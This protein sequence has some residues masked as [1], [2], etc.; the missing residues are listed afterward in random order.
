MR[1]VPVTDRLEVL[2]RGDL[3]QP[4]ALHDRSQ[5]LRVGR[6]AEDVRDDEGDAAGLD[7][8]DDVANLLLGRRD[9][10]LQ[11]DV[12]V[13]VG[14]GD[15]RV[16]VVTILSADEDAVDGEP[17]GDAVEEEFT[18]IGEAGVGREVMLV[19]DAVSHL[20]ARV[21]HGHQFGAIGM[22]ESPVRIARATG[23][24]THHGKT[25]TSHC[26]QPSADQAG[27]MQASSTDGRAGRHL[28]HHG[29]VS[30]PPPS[31]GGQV[32]VDDMRATRVKA[33]SI[34]IS[35]STYGLGF[36]ALAVTTGLSVAQTMALSILLFSGGSQF[37]FIGLI[38]AG[39]SGAAV[40][41]STLLGLRNGVYAIALRRLVPVTGL[42]RVLAAQLTIDESTAVA[43]GA[44]TPLSRSRGF[45]LTGLVV[46]AGWNLATLAGAL[47]GDRLGDPATYGLDAV[48]PAAFLALLWP[49]L[50]NTST[51]VVAVIAVAVALLLAPILP[52][53]APVLAAG[54]VA[55]TAGVLGRGREGPAR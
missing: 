18:P 30:A 49:R 23:A 36:G 25:D 55:I 11:Q 32:V 39:A 24:G 1:E 22:L 34:G 47:L 7:R 19:A 35:T 41:S 48:G 43:L 14:E 2:D 44:A 51:R 38:G 29:A 31:D 52:A 27:G 53:G 16:V 17:L 42:R 13:R 6:V 26:A 28:W 40:A 15:G 21:G 37:A 45:W 54:L 9:R 5:R 50:A 12:D 8:L 20:G 10:L 33:L 4:A 46:Y 3:A